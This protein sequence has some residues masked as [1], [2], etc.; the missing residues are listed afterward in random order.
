MIVYNYSEFSYIK[1]FMR[2]ETS[3]DLFKKRK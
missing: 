3:R 2:R 1:Y